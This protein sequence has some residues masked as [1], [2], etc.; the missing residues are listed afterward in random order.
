[1][2]EFARAAVPDKSP[3]AVGVRVARG[4]GRG[5]L[6]M[7][8]GVPQGSPTDHTPVRVGA[9][10]P[11]N[12]LREAQAAGQRGGAKSGRLLRWPGGW[13][14]LTQPGQGGAETA[15]RHVRSLGSLVRSS[16]RRRLAIR[17]VGRRRVATRFH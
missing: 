12:G 15:A 17:R 4:R 2:F 13:R 10:P 1:M 5:E 7:T 8:P 16:S 3:Q 14:G 6:W 9:R 11:K